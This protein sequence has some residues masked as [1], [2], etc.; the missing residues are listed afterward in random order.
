MVREVRT[1]WRLRPHLKQLKK[2]T[3]MKLSTNMVVT[4]LM[5]AAN[6]LNS[7]S[8]LLAPKYRLYG[9]GAQVII[10]AILKLIAGFRNPDGSTAR[11][12]WEPESKTSPRLP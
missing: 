5:T 1:W 10:E 4:F 11:I 7:V 9:W 2:L 12:P 3:D 6:A 8:D